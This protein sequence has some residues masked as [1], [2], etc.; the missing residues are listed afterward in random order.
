MSAITQ[1]M[2][3]ANRERVLTLGEL[4]TACIEAIKGGMDTHAPVVMVDPTAYEC[5]QI[6][7][8]GPGGVIAEIVHESRLHDGRWAARL[9]EGEY[10]G[11][12][13]GPVGE[14]R[15]RRPPAGHEARAVFLVST[16]SKRWTTHHADN[17]LPAPED[18]DAG[19]ARGAPSTRAREVGRKK[20]ESRHCCRLSVGPEGEGGDP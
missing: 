16:W 4:Y 13:T 14:L 3:L 15:M 1:E 8:A 7:H 11:G 10:C 20:E 2:V 6:K 19:C 9:G 18:G 5:R 17:T 12:L